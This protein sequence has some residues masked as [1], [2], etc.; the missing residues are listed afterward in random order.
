MMSSSTLMSSMPTLMPALSGIVVHRIRLAREAGERRA[1]V[2]VGVHADAEP[3]HAVAAED[4]DDAEQQ[5]DDDAQ[6]RP[7]PRARRS[8]GR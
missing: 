4:A 1:G 8:T 2:G 3:G 7:C 6:R 5:D